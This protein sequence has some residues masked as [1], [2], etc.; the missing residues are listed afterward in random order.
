[1]LQDRQRKP[2]PEDKA[3]PGQQPGAQPQAKQQQRAQDAAQAAR[4]ATG[5]ASTAAL[6]P[7]LPTVVVDAGD[8]LWDIAVAVYDDGNLW[9]ELWNANRARV[10]NAHS[11]SPGTVLVLP[12][13]REKQAH[14]EVPKP[15]E[16]MPVAPPNARTHTVRAGET[17]ISIAAQE[18]GGHHRW[19]EIWDLNRATVKDPDR[20]RLGQVLTLP[21]AQPAPA[22]PNEPAKSPE[23]KKAEPPPGQPANLPPPVPHDRKKAVGK[24][25]S[26]R[27]AA[28]LYNEKGPLIASEAARIAIE[29]G[30]AAACMLTETG[31]LRAKNGRMTIRF[32]PH[33]FHKYT[34]KTVEDTHANQAAE[35]LAFEA[36]KAIDVG[37]A[38]ESISMG[39]AQVMGFNAGRLGYADAQQMFAAMSAS[40]DT[41]AVGFFEFIRTSHALHTAAK[42]RDWPTF[43]RLYNGPKYAENAYDVKM[44]THY[45]SWQRVTKGLDA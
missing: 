3:K 8:T 29:P 7:N 11:L 26:E 19:N 37:A 12:P 41:Q 23:G 45:A 9:I 24:T 40:E 35:W 10:P 1:M 32:E 2:E 44:A 34:G 33:V 13:L 38:Y 21:T 20:L 43:A 16:P 28:N 15:A 27:Q 42:E 4:P 31:G 39:T 6:D 30:V 5:L 18:L 17:L 22:K 36:A 14:A 25:P